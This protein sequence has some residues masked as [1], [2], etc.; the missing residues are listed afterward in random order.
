MIR[1]SITTCGSLN[2]ICWKER[3]HALQ[4]TSPQAM[5]TAKKLT[6][7]TSFFPAAA[8]VGVEV[9]ADAEGVPTVPPWT[10]AGETVPFALA[11]AA[12]YCARV[13]EPSLLSKRTREYVGGDSVQGGVGNWKRGV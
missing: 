5:R 1:L 11:A 2:S 9:A 6:S 13:L 4:A 8:L 10:R 12:L 3:I 7:L